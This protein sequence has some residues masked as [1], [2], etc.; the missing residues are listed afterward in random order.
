MQDSTGDALEWSARSPGFNLI[1]V[2]IALSVTCMG[3]YFG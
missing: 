3:H 1:A 2:E